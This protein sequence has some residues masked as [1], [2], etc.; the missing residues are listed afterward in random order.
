MPGAISL[1]PR[2]TIR[3]IPSPNL[4]LASRLG[5]SSRYIEVPRKVERPPLFA[6]IRRSSFL[7]L[8]AS[9]FITGA[10]RR[11][12]HQAADLPSIVDATLPLE[13]ANH[14]NSGAF[15]Y[16]S[17]CSIRDVRR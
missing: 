4:V 13:V 7:N 12:P 9:T 3:S 5:R 10:S 15:V 16:D 14:I 17:Y 6:A 2:T 8:L 1:R 11:S